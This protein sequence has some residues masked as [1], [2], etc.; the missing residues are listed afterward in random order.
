MHKEYAKGSR[1]LAIASL[2]DSVYAPP[3]KKNFNRETY[4]LVANSTVLWNTKQM[5]YIHVFK[6]IAGKIFQKSFGQT[7]RNWRNIYILTVY[8]V[9]TLGLSLHK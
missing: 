4:A 2:T 9:K 1:V 7:G 5:L 3:P 6:V 8:V